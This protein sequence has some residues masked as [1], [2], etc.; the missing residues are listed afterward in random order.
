MGFVR[1]NV[2]FNSKYRGSWRHQGSRVGGDA[3]SKS[4]NPG[5]NGH[6]SLAVREPQTRPES[7]DKFRW[8]FENAVEGMFQTTPEGMYLSVNPALAR[9]YGYASPA[10][11]TE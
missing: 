11:L 8:L 1:P 10:E 4:Q 7:S 6:A 2:T 3:T 5:T 9:M